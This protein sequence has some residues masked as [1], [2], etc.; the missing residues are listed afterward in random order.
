MDLDKPQAQDIQAVFK[1]RGVARDEESRENPPA[2]RRRIGRLNRLWIDRRGMASPPSDVSAEVLDR[3]K[4]DQS[5]DDEEDLPMY[6][7]DPFDTNALRF[8]ASIPLPPWMTNRVAV[9]NARAPLPPPQQPQQ[10]QPSIPQPQPQ[11]VPQPQV[12]PQAQTGT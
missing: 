1:F 5:S 6:D 8:R 10:P 3:W 4:Y 12:P 2:Y 7:A 9:P 11:T